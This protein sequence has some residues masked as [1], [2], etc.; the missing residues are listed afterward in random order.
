MTEKEKNYLLNLARKS[1]KEYLLRSEKYIPPEPNFNFVKKERA[2]FVTLHKDGQL[3]GCIGH[4]H[5]Q[6]PLYLAVAEMAVSAAFQDP[7]FPKLQKNEL[8][9]IEIEIS[10][11]SPMQR[12]QDYEQIRIGKDGVWVK[13]GFQSGVYLPQVAEETGWDREQF[14][15]SLCA[16]KAGLPKDAYKDP[17]IELYIF[18]VEK[19]SE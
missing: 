13:K 3:R 14:L 5:A 10:V 9:Q 17:D 4:M 16:H 11:L 18:Q 8:P 2:V 19:F 7:R 12:I 15:E 6:M 1:I